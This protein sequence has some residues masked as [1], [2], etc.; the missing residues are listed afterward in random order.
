MIS[1]S[2][3]P[4]RIDFT[5]AAPSNRSSRVV[6]NSRPFG[7]AP[8]QWPDRP[9]RCNATAIDRVELIWQTRSTVPTSMPNS[10]DAVATSTRTSPFLSLRSAVRR[11]FRER[12]P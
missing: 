11:S 5:R 8:R 6:T 3:S 1:R 12:L 2:S 4:S 10:S 7:T 9:T